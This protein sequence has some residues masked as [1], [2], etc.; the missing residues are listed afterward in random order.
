MRVALLCETF[1]KNMGYLQTVLPKFMDRLGINTHVIT[2]DLPPYYQ[3]TAFCVSDCI[4]RAGTEEVVNGFRLHTLAHSKVAGYMR[5]DRLKE[6]LSIIRPDIVQT[7]SPVG[8]IALDA[9]LMKSIYNYKLFIGCHTTA[10]VFPLARERVKS[11][12]RERMW[13]LIARTI[14]GRVVGSMSEKCYAVTEDCADIAIRYFG[15]PRNKVEVMYLGIDTDYCFPAHS[16]E[17]IEEREKVRRQLYFSP[18]DIVCIYTGKFTH[19]KQ[20][21]LL[22][23]AIERVQARKKPFKALFIGS[24]PL[25]GELRRRTGCYVVDTVPYRELPKFYRASDIGVWPGTESISMLDAAACGIPI[26]ISGQVVYRAPIN[27]N[28]RVFQSGNVEDLANVLCE[29]SDTGLRREL[30]VK[31]AA[32]MASEFSWESV[33]RRRVADYE[34]ALQE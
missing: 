11:Q 27:G 34:R 24:G 17:S 13:C 2:M 18:G 12:Y 1:D 4:V 23:S 29:L 14:P 21:L 33:A 15:V 22:A 20:V 8:W 25:S 26:V 7:M 32:R 9:A 6:K 28:G 16:R 3:S 30:G 19:E 31:G 5:M 10:S